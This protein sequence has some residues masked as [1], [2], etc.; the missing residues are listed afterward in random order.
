[1]GKWVRFNYIGKGRKITRK[2]QRVGNEHTVQVEDR[3]ETGLI[4]ERGIRELVAES[5]ESQV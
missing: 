2:L 1:M 5:A 4:G 3:K